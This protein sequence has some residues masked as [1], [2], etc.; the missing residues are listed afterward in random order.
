MIKPLHKVEIDTTTIEGKASATAPQ[1]MGGWTP[2]MKKVTEASAAT[3]KLLT[4]DVILPVKNFISKLGANV[5][6]TQMVPE[7]FKTQVVA[8]TNY[9]VVYKIN[10]TQKMEVKIWKKLDGTVQVTGASEAYSAEVD[11]N[12]QTG[13]LLLK[14]FEDNAKQTME[15]LLKKVRKNFNDEDVKKKYYKARAIYNEIAEQ[16]GSDSP[17]KKSERETVMKAVV[18]KKKAD[19]ITCV[20][21]VTTM[22]DLTETLVKVEVEPVVVAAIEDVQDEPEM[23]ETVQEAKEDPEVAAELAKGLVEAK[24]DEEVATAI[25]NARTKAQLKK[26]PGSYAQMTIR[27]GAKLAITKVKTDLA[28]K[29]AEREVEKEIDETEDETKMEDIVVKIN[30]KAEEMKKKMEAEVVERAKGAQSNIGSAIAT[31]TKQIRNRISIWRVRTRYRTFRRRWS[32][33]L[34]KVSE[35]VGKALNDVKDDE[36][37]EKVLGEAKA[38]TTKV[39]TNIKESLEKFQK[40]ELPKEEMVEEKKKEFEAVVKKAAEEVRSKIKGV[41]IF[42]NIARLKVTANKEMRQMKDKMSKVIVKATETK[43]ADTAMKDLELKAKQI[44]DDL[45]VKIQ[46][47]VDAGKKLVKEAEKGNIAVEKIP[48]KFEPTKAIEFL[49]NEEFMKKTGEVI[50]TE[51]VTAIETAKKQATQKVKRCRVR[52]KSKHLKERLEKQK[53]VIEVHKAKVKKLRDEK[54]ASDKKR[55]EVRKGKRTNVIY[56]KW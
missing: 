32:L 12:K 18:N 5:Q 29:K 9:E 44:A 56:T 41:K 28:V 13:Q 4:Q 54:K 23:I 43:A 34:R 36:E 27:E 2:A 55:E 39:E 20:K 50:R 17:S 53:K 26:N 45:K 1:L 6:I 30:K 40:V 42:E 51:I 3:K 49:N 33:R 35:K 37:V 21:K 7:S 52:V 8:G 14:K 31:A 16:T 47:Q 19:I 38:E 25:V 11:K 10:P 22:N 48:K 46:I 15:G 24:D